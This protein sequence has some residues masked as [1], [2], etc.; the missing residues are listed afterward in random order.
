MGGLKLAKKK[1]EEQSYVIVASPSVTANLI[2]NEFMKFGNLSSLYVNI[3]TSCISYIFFIW[4]YFLKNKKYSYV[5]PVLWIF[6]F[7]WIFSHL[8][9]KNSGAFLK[10]L[11]ASI[12]ISVS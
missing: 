4:K 1:P 11:P 7:G 5:L 2:T 12:P 6:F 3:T 9:G 8:L 10:F